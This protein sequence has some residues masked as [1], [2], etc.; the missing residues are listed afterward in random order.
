MKKNKVSK[1]KSSESPNQKSQETQS[2]KRPRRVAAETADSLIKAQLTETVLIETNP[3]SK[4][5]SSSMKK[6]ILCYANG[7]GQVVTASKLKLVPPELVVISQPQV[8]ITPELYTAKLPSRNKEGVFQY[9]DYPEFKPNLSPAEVL[10]KGSFG[11]YYFRTIAST[12]TGKVHVDA[13]KEFPADWFKGMNANKLL[14]A[15]NKDPSVNA[16]GVDCGQDLEAWEGSNWIVEQDPFG[17]FQWYCRFFQGRRTTDDK[18]QVARWVGVAGVKG[19]WK[20]N[21][22]HKVVLADATFDDPAISPVVRQT[23]QH[24]AYALT[25]PD[26]LLYAKKVSKGAKTSFIRN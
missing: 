21:L 26:F 7:K 6:A 25:E 12:V 4:P 18:R 16:F 14:C 8:R 3:D 20:N 22:I 19:R 10:Q 23:L 15:P 17:W 24:W 9:A 11:G 1:R 5:I 13:F 2:V